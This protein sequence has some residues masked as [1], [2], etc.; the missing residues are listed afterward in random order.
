MLIAVIGG[1]LQGVEA[2]YLAQKA[3]W[4][5]LVIDK[6]PDAPATGMC[7][8]FLKFEF[9]PETVEPFGCPSVDLILPAI[10]DEAVLTAVQTWS[11]MKKIPLAF[12]LEAYRLSSSKLESHALFEKNHLPAPRSW[13]ECGYPVVVK[14]NRA[15]GSHGVEII[16]DSRT[17]STRFPNQKEVDHLVLQEYMEGP[18][19][20]IEV[21]GCPG[22]YQVFQVTDL[23]MDDSYDCKRVTAPTR[24]PLEQIRIFEKTA[25]TIAEEIRLKGIMDVEVILHNGSLKLLE[26]D[27]RLPSQTPMAVYGSTGI[28][29]VERLGNLFLNTQT[30]HAVIAQERCIVVEHIRVSGSKIDVLGEHIMATEGP[31][32]RQA[33]FLGA[34][35]AITSFAP[36]KAAW[37]AT[38]IFTGNTHAAVAE[39]KQMCYEKIHTST[40]LKP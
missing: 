12:D 16:K 30:G 26:I 14:P 6:N 23:S 37:V 13:P 8:H 19:Y 31:L 27:A 36:G 15:S 38:L 35:E 33:D 32:T 39:K 1:K 9:T 28:N 29:M 25:L 7:D 34:D 40:C 4:Q 20:S 21:V 10:E 2:V 3:G 11:H 22:N 5:T 24:L 17:F 18:S